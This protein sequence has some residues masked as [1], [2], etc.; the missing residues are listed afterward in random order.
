MTGPGPELQAFLHGKAH[1]A[2]I[3]GSSWLHE[4]WNAYAYTTFRASICFC[5]NYSFGFR[6]R[7]EPITQLE[8]AAQLISA[9][10]DLGVKIKK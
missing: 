2:Q 5:S 4:W 10:I 3:H 7:C 1:E 9:F 6:D 8:R